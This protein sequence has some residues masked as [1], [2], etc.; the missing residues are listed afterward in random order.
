MTEYEIHPAATIFPLAEDTIPELAE[1]IRKNGLLDP[2]DLFEGKVLDGRRR[3]RACKLAGVEPRFRE[4]ATECPVTY[5]LSKQTRRDLTK[6][7]RSMAAARAEKLRAKLAAEAK[8]RRVEGNSAGGKASG[9]SRRGKSVEGLPPTS[10][11]ETKLKSRDQI[12]AL[13]GVSGRAVACADKV[14]RDGVPELVEAVDAN[15]IGVVAGS[16][17]A[18]LEPEEQREKVAEMTAPG[19]KPRR[20]RKAESN[21]ETPPDESGEP[22]TDKPAR[23]PGKLLG[24]GVV[25]AHEAVAI[26]RR[27]PQNDPLR[28]DGFKIVKDWLRRESK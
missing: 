20:K 7:D 5:A 19:G 16:K 4:V 17:I 3:L 2:I 22:T 21:D 10:E 11:K 26:L 23:K 14:I 8:E 12:G 27:I 18:T 9:Q 6:A 28:K 25:R 1:D 24:V 15:K 13:M